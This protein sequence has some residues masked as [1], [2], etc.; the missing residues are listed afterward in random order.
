MK[1]DLEPGDTFVFNMGLKV[2]LVLRND[3]FLLIHSHIPSKVN[4][5]RVQKLPEDAKLCDPPFRAEV[6]L[7]IQG[8]C[9]ANCFKFVVKNL[10]SSELVL[11]SRRDLVKMFAG[12]LVNITLTETLRKS[13]DQK[14]VMCKTFHLTPDSIDIELQNGH[15]LSI[16]PETLTENS[17]GGRI[18]N[19]DIAGT[20]RIITLV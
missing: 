19:G 16:V 18:S 4:F 3:N 1:T 17:V 15:R 11:L 2:G 7:A 9:I 8:I 14:S 5:E 6:E 13:R 20:K 12:K 10:G